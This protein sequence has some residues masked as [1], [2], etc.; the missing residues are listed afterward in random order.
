M[1]S[2]RAQVIAAKEDTAAS[3]IERSEVIHGIYLGLLA[4]KNV[5][6]LGPPGTAKS[7]TTRE[8]LNRLSGATGFDLLMTR[9]TAPDEVFGP[10]KLSAL[11]NDKYERATDGY[12]ASVN[13]L[14]LDEIFK[15]NSAILNALLTLL[16][17]RKY[18]NGAVFMDCPLVTCVGASNE[19][20]QGED[21]SALY[22]RFLLRFFVPYISGDDEFSALLRLVPGGPNATLS[23]ATLKAA[24]DEVRRVRMP[25]SVIADILTLRQKLLGQGIRASDRRWREVIPVLQ[26]EAWMA[27]RDE[28]STADLAVLANTHWDRPDEASKVRKHV[29]SFALPNLERALELLDMATEQ[30]AIVAN[31]LDESAKYEASGKLRKIAEEITAIA[32][33]DKHTRII[34]AEKRVNAMRRDVVK[35]M[36]G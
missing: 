31:G 18:R 32:K 35:L 27:G 13:V 9:F 16:N 3:L 5:F 19:L 21:L 8:T 6:L 33:S 26:A 17:E 11:Q 30:R 12:A 20:P 1:V 2:V 22:D 29:L 10:I 34:D 14:F 24:Q 28:V 25:D 4:R 23:L 36:T 15:A 7:L